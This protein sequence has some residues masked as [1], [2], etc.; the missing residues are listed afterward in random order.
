MR[1]IHLFFAVATLA[2]VSAIA[3]AGPS[4]ADAGLYI[5]DGRTAVH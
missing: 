1:L 4:Q 5:Q 2:A 3:L